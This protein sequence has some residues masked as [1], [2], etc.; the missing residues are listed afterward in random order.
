MTSLPLLAPSDKPKL[1]GI[2]RLASEGASLREGHDVEYFT[3][4]S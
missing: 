1:I 4:A 3:L 2:A